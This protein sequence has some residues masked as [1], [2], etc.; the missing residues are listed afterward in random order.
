MF[1]STFSVEYSVRIMQHY[2]SVTCLNVYVV[3][4][5]LYTFLHVII[6]RNIA[7]KFCQIYSQTLFR[8]IGRLTAFPFVLLTHF[9]IKVRVVLRTLKYEIQNTTYVGR[10]SLNFK[11]CHIPVYNVCLYNDRRIRSFLTS[12]ATFLPSLSFIWRV[13]FIINLFP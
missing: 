1:S 11:M 9:A 2:F 6:P 7:L 3:P 12:F 13:I 10:G 4:T 5:F 8:I